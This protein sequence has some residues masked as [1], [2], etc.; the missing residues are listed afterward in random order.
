MKSLFWLL[1]LFSSASLAAYIDADMRIPMNPSE[2]LLSRDQTNSKYSLI[3]FGIVSMALGLGLCATSMF[4]TDRND[5]IM[6]NA[7]GLMTACIGLFSLLVTRCT[8]FG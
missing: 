6:F 8:S 7:V 5:I 3:G 2:P 4:K 1:V